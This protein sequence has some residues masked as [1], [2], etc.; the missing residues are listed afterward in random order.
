MILDEVVDEVPG[1]PGMPGSGGLHGGKGLKRPNSEV[2][3][4][5]P[6]LAKRGK[7]GIKTVHLKFGLIFPKSISRKEDILEITLLKMIFCSLNF[8]TVLLKQL[9]SISFYCR[10]ISKIAYVVRKDEA[11]RTYNIEVTLQ[12]HSDFNMQGIMSWFSLGVLIA[13]NKQ[14]L[15]MPSLLFLRF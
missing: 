14:L 6:G 8:M 4:A 12:Y 15:L 9:S 2:L 3:P 13:K 11:D 7:K 5:M 10:V 1:V